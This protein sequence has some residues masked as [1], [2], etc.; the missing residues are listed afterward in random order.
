MNYARKLSENSMPYENSLPSFIQRAVRDI[1][2][3]TMLCV[4]G[5][6]GHAEGQGA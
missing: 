3:R 1:H 5:E 4:E 2:R 6:G